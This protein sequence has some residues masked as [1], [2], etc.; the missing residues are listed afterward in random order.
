MLADNSADK[1]LLTEFYGSDELQNEFKTFAVYAAYKRA[2]AAGRVRLTRSGV[3]A[4][5]R[6]EFKPRG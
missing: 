6:S 2:E 3:T 1:K 4:P 5:A